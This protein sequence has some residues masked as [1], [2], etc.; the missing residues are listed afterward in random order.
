MRQAA[1]LE[2]YKS[3]PAQKMKKHIFI[4]IIALL[5]CLTLNAQVPI[6]VD[7]Q[8]LKAEDERRYDKTLED[9]LKHPHY[10]VRTRAALAAGRIGDARAISALVPLLEKGTAKEREMAAFAFGEIES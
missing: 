5:N 10:N 2:S 6:D 3:F 1:L 7:V 4:L 8:I 9:L